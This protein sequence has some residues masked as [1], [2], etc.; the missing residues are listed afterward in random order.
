MLAC[1]TKTTFV[2]REAL[3]K[4]SELDIVGKRWNLEDFDR[5]RFFCLPDFLKD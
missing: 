2:G 5:G 4:E 1:Y 3:N